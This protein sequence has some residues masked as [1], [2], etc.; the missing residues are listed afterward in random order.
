MLHRVFEFLASYREGILPLESGESEIEV[1]LG[2]TPKEVW[3]RKCNV[4]GM[5]VCGADHDW[6]DFEITNNGFIIFS[7]V[8]SESIV[9]EWFVWF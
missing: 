5:N 3:V 1:L 8:K 2:R 9:I 7:D 6:L 4:E